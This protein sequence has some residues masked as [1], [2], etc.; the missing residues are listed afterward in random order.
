MTVS[1]YWK[2]LLYHLSADGRFTALNMTDSS[3]YW[4]LYSSEQQLVPLPD[5]FNMVIGNATDV[6]GSCS[7]GQGLGDGYFYSD[8]GNSY[9]IPQK[10][11]SHLGTHIQ[12]PDCWDRQ[13]FTLQTQAE[14]TTFSDGDTSANCPEGY[15]RIPGLIISVRPMLVLFA[16]GR[17]LYAKRMIVHI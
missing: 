2:P 7:N 8:F 16:R 9:T 5:N 11:T 6:N 4:D 14:H 12:F 13:P 1:S 15:S 3:I 10:Y 17:S